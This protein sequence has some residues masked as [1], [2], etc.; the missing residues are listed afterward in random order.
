MAELNE[1][2]QMMKSLRKPTE[3][4]KMLQS[5]QLS[6]VQIDNRVDRKKSCNVGIAFRKSA[7]IQPRTSP[8]TACVYI[9]SSPE[10]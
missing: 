7:S 9:F 10:I 5:L 3:I 6:P 1:H 8:P 4:L 2:L